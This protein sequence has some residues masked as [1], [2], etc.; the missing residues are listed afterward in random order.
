MRLECLRRG[1]RTVSLNGRLWAQ[2]VLPL[3]VPKAAGPVSGASVRYAG[4]ERRELVGSG[5]AAFGKAGGNSR[6]RGTSAFPKKDGESR[7]GL[8]SR[9]PFQLEQSG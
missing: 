1:Q 7:T 4:C 2:A 3:S 8:L 5:T 6:H 9:K